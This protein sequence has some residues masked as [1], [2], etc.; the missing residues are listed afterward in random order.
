MGAA[1]LRP[2][3]KSYRIRANVSE[4]YHSAAGAERMPRAAAAQ[5]GTGTAGKLERIAAAPSA[6]RL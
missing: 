1:Q 3:H 2:L 5:L 4:R 6:A